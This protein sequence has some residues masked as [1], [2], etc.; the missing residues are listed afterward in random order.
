M[1]MHSFAY[2]TAHSVQEALEVLSAECR[3]LAGGTDL[4]GMMKEELI[5]PPKLV[6]LKRIPGLD[7]VEEREDGLHIGALTVLSQLM[8]TPSVSRRKELACLYQA[9]LRTASPQLRHMATLGGNLLQRPRCWYFRNKLTHCL[10]KGGERCFAF[11]GENK[12]HAI[13]GGGPCYIVHP[14]DPAVALLA[15]DAAVTVEGAGSTRRVPLTDFY[16]LPGVDP[17]NEVALAADE[18][19]TEVFIP[20]P[21]AGSR[22]T[23]LKA[24]E[25]GSWD[26]ALVS[27][28]VQLHFSGQVVEKARVALGGVAPVPWRAREAE[29]VLLGNRLTDHVIEQAARAATAGARPLA[30][31]GYKI[32]L[33]QG[34]VRQA[35]RGVR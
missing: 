15:L 34:L 22:G 27:L 10:R 20:A 23:Y 8:T 31:N 18:L 2:A 19:V 30:Q 35:L 29:N 26:L 13:L 11:R 17:H 16:L 21:K 1:A 33:A 28:A 7:Q 6:N 25:R 14:S 32:D 4:V 5:A 12:Y 9:L 3:P 24:A